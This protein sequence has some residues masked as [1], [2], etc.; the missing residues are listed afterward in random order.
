MTRCVT[1]EKPLNRNKA[2]M[3]IEYENETFLVC[4][5][6]CQAEFEKNPMRY[7]HRSRRKHARS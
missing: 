4:C 1:C 3:S 5:P 7:I 2:Y 6:L